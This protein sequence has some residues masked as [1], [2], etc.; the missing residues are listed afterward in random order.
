MKTV[1]LILTALALLTAGA[2]RASEP[3]RG[4]V[5]EL[6]SC[7]VF[8]G[9][10]IASSEATLEG[11]YALRA[12]HFSRGDLQGLTVA[13]LQVA[14]DN[15]AARPNSPAQTVV[16]LPACATESQR[17]ALLKWARPTGR[18]I[19]RIVPIR[20]ER[21]GLAATLTAGD[22]V[23]VTTGPLHACD[24]GGCGES[25]WYKPLSATAFEPAVNRHSTVNE[26][27]LALRWTDNGRRSAFIG[28]F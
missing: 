12:W 24:R 11:R 15:L 5:L 23:R 28:Q 10:C 13:T 14:D 9:G 21:D 4:E 19:T 6:Y 16:Y 25:L 7:E 27:S 2:S 26:P 8:T 18:F 20:F 1:A 3:A 17:Q 22:F